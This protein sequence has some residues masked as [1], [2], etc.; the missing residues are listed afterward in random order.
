MEVADVEAADPEYAAARIDQGDAAQHRLA[1]RTPNRRRRI[2]E[3]HAVRALG[4]LHG[5][6]LRVCEVVRV[7][8]V[9]LHGPILLHHQSPLQRN[10]R[11]TAQKLELQH[12]AADKLRLPVDEVQPRPGGPGLA[13]PSAGGGIQDQEGPGRLGLLEREHQ[14]VELVHQERPQELGTPPQV[15]RRQ[16]PL[17]QKVFDA[18]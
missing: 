13:H 2:P 17:L 7:L 15:V 16:L 18:A 9:E 12:A 4:M 5:A 8:D 6:S 1:G 3:P 14:V 10:L 11:G